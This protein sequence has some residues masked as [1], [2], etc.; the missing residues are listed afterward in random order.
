MGRTDYLVRSY[1][2]KSVYSSAAYIII[3]N[4]GF[5]EGNKHSELKRK[6]SFSFALLSFFIT[7][8]PYNIIWI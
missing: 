2:V 5:A 8:V 4:F 7:F 3:Y 6:K 1:L